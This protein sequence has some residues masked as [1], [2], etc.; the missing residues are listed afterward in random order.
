[1]GFLDKLLN[2]GARILK[3]AA[4][5]ALENAADEIISGLKGNEAQSVN[6]S[7]RRDNCEAVP[8]TDCDDYEMVPEGYDAALQDEDVEVKL[9]TVLAKEFPQYEVREQVSPTTL[10]G[11][12]KFLPYTFGV[13]ENDRPKL[14][15]M[16]VGKNTCQHRDYR[17]S[18]E[19]AQKA[20][21]TMINFVEA[22]DNYINY[23]IERLHQYL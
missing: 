17:W 9:R 19:E 5:D 15:I 4:G 7:V 8:D 12:G 13:Y 2:Q 10:G 14:F 6:S 20:G 22:F 21:V 18:K 1:M 3:E 16:V 23:I 11:T